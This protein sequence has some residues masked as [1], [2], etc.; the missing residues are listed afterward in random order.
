MGIA[1]AA[2]YHGVNADHPSGHPMGPSSGG[3]YIKTAMARWLDP[4]WRS[5]ALDKYGHVSTWDT[6]GVTNMGY[7][8]DCSDSWR[9]NDDISA[10]DTSRVTHM[11]GTLYR[12]SAFNRPI[13]GWNVNKVTSMY[14][15]FIDCSSF[16]Q[17]LNDWQVDNVTDMSL[18]FH[19]AKSFNQ[20]LND[21]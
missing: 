15:L 10:W 18:M 2:F 20:P 5:Y 7:M 3:S 4:T 6:G 8:T 16:N 12:A 9:F 14:R 17:P 19:G 21:W 13:G 11:D 1:A